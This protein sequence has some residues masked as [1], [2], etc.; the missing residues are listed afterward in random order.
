MGDVFYLLMVGGSNDT[1]NYF[2]SQAIGL[3]VEA[4]LIP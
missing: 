2:R 3:I 1:Q 4:T